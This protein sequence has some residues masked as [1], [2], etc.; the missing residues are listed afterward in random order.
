[1][2]VKPEVED[3]NDIQA[4]QVEEGTVEGG[5][6]KLYF[7]IQKKEH[8]GQEMGIKPGEIHK[9]KGKKLGTD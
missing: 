2:A 8:Q 1:M 5:N 9:L 7:T 6:N 4:E 3:S